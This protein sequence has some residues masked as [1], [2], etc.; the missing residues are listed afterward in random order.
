MV[1]YDTGFEGRIRSSAGDVWICIIYESEVTKQ[2]LFTIVSLTV[3]AKKS[4]QMVI[5][6][7]DMGQYVTAKSLLNS[8]SGACKKPSWHRSR[9]FCW[10]QL[11]ST[12]FT[13]VE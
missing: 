1:S 6:C 10:P 13:Q 11:Y 5:H 7:E 3:A 2:T 4:I 12:H 8:V 9:R